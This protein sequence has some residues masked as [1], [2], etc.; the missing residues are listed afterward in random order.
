MF[1]TV[2]FYGSLI[3]TTLCT[4]AS[5]CGGTFVFR[6]G[7]ERPVGCSLPQRNILARVAFQACK[8]VMHHERCKEQ[9]SIR[10][11]VMKRWK[12]ATSLMDSL[13]PRPI[14]LVP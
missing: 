3:L 14:L 8:A 12:R 13:I 2:S 1:D 6:C 7:S 11:S 10:V 4:L 9:S 5:A